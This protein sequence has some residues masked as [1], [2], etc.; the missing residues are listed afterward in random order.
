MF[1]ENQKTNNGFSFNIIFAQNMDLIQI[2]DLIYLQFKSMN[3]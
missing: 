1:F 2:T 3:Q